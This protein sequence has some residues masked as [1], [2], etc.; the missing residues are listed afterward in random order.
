[1]KFLR[2]LFL[3]GC[4]ASSAYAAGPTTTAV[5][6]AAQSTANLTAYNVALNALGDPASI[7]IPSWVTSYQVTALKI[8]NCSATPV[9][10]TVGLYSAASG[11]GTA[12]VTA[13]TITGATSAT[14][15]LSPAIASTGTF[16]ASTLYI[17]VT[18]ANAAAL[19]CTFKVNIED[20]S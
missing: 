3:A 10:A 4:L 15:V 7:A 20:F 18:V 17:H 12:I 11:G 5:N 16:S 8:T 13:A 2:N 9:L 6:S 14:I 1:M 19:T